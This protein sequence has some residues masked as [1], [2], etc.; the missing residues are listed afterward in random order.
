[1]EEAGEGTEDIRLNWK[2]SFTELRREKSHA[3]IRW[4]A[5]IEHYVVDTIT[6]NDRTDVRRALIPVIVY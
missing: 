4:L 6:E 1:L 5:F 3:G 2:H